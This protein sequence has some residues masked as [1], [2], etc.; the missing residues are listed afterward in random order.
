MKQINIAN[1]QTKCFLESQKFPAPEETQMFIAVVTT[2]HH[3]EEDE[4][5]RTLP[6][7]FFKIRFNIT[8]TFTPCYS[9]SPLSLGYADMKSDTCHMSL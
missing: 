9:N 6:S 3:H 1:C 8:L 5:F 4:P 7:Y 2:S